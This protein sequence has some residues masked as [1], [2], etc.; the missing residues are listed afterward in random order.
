[1]VSSSNI[2]NPWPFL[3]PALTL[4]CLFFLLPTVNMVFLSLT[5]ESGLGFGNFK[6]FFET[7]HLTQALGRSLLLAL[8]S[9][10]IAGFV[11]WPLAYFIVFCVKEKWRPLFLLAI[12]APF[13]TS[14]T[15]RAFSWQL[16]L[17]DNG[18]ITWLIEQLTGLSIALGFLYTMKASVFGLAL[19]GSMLCTFTLYGALVSIDKKVIE[20][21]ST[22]G[23]KPFQIFRDIILPLG[24]PGWLAGVVLSF[25][26]CIG[27][28]AVPTLLGGGLKPVLA[29]IMLSVL[30]GTYNLSQAATIATILAITVIIC[31]APLMLFRH[32]FRRSILA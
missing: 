18:V 19:F 16:V 22:L 20:A 24:L 2:A 32:L 10:A 31:A 17:S 1:M 14:F 6:D 8:F 11:A 9:T 7:P 27:D 15:I 23:A 5:S 13:W 30:K 29:Q 3:L 21:A 26:V 4:S 28:Y 25:I 12:L